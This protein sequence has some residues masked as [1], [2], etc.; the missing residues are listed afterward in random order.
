[1]S[2]FAVQEHKKK[3]SH[4]CCFDD[5][6]F[7]FDENVKLWAESQVCRSVPCQ[8][9]TQ[10]SWVC[11]SLAWKISRGKSCEGFSLPNSV[12]DTTGCT[13]WAHTHR[14]LWACAYH[15]QPIVSCTE[16]GR[17]NS[18]QNFPHK[19]FHARL[20]QTCEIASRSGRVQFCKLATLLTISH[21]CQVK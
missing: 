5:A 13:W 18:S 8:T 19:I 10:I 16:L 15:V 9:W 3:R 21:F 11:H 1:M 14:T 2:R 17:E 12:Q 6:L 4:K 7:H 20:W